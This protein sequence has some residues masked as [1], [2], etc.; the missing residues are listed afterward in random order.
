MQEAWDVFMSDGEAR[1][2]TVYQVSEEYGPQW[3][4][5]SKSK[6][7]KLDSIHINQKDKTQ[8]LNAIT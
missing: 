2:T 8:A 6:A 1:M 4:P 3:A 5:K 7:R